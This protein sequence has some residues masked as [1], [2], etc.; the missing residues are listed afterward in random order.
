MIELR[1]VW[2]GVIYTIV[3]ECGITSE[4]TES[5]DNIGTLTCPS[6]KASCELEA[7]M[8]EYQDMKA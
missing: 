1:K 8:D 3:C 5:W 4:V 6:C 7:V 2:S